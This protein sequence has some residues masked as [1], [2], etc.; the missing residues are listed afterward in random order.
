ME[1][2]RVIVYN[3]E[4][5]EYID[6][7]L[8]GI[9]CDT[10]GNIDYH[11]YLDGTRETEITGMTYT[12]HVS[13]PMKKQCIELDPT[14]MKRIAKYNKE[15]EIEKLNEEIKNKKKQIKE[16]DNKLHDRE[17]RWQRVKNYIANIYDMDLNEEDE[18]DWDWED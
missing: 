13:Y 8:C 18:D 4:N 17:Q 9:D 10:E 3:Q 12:I 1:N 7:L 14:T 5:L 2:C 6:G 11:Y 15:I 16:L